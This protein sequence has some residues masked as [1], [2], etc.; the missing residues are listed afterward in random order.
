MG[1]LMMAMV[2]RG[3]KM[4]SMVKN[5]EQEVGRRKEKFVKLLIKTVKLCN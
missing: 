5:F 4:E 2:G 1:A 3:R